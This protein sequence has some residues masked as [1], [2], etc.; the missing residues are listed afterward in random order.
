MD[1]LWINECGLTWRFCWAIWFPAETFKCLFPL[2]LPLIKPSVQVRRKTR[3]WQLKWQ[4]PA[5]K[6][7]KQRSSEERTAPT[8]C[9]LFLRRWALTQLMSN[10]GASMFLAALSSLLWGLWEREGP[11]RS[12]Q[13]GLAWTEEWLGSQVRPC[14][15]HSSCFLFCP[16]LCIPSVGW[17]CD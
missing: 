13:E 15:F 6:Q 10:T 16:S 17:M 2:R 1:E 3:T 14:A 4:V 5:G 11:I 8:V 9:A 7:R 12:E